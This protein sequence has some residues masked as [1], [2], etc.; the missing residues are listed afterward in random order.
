MISYISR[1]KYNSKFCDFKSFLDDSKKKVHLK[2]CKN[3]LNGKA[4]SEEDIMLFGLGVFCRNYLDDKHYYVRM[5]LCCLVYVCV[6][7]E[8]WKH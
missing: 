1:L 7:S 3:C 4:L 6:C 5:I 2:L 8:N